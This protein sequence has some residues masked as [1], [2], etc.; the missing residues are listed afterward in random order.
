VKWEL[1]FLGEKVVE[2]KVRLSQDCW[3]CGLFDFPR[4]KSSTWR[5]LA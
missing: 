2:W 3:R 5:S 4:G 1:L